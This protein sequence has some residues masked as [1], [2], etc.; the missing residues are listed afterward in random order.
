[1]GQRSSPNDDEKE[2]DGFTFEMIKGDLFTSPQSASLCHCVAR[3][4]GMG[5]GIAV[6]FKRN[7]GGLGELRKQ[8]VPVGGVGVLL[9]DNR[10][11]Y[12]LVTK[13]KSTDLPTSGPLTASLKSMRDHAVAN[14]VKHIAMPKI[15][16]GL[17]RLKW[18]K[19][20]SSIMKIFEE[21]DIR[22]TVY[23]K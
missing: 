19:V 7:F 18:N 5:K 13:K 9:R 14:G 23:E 12:Y 2:T 1:M 6:M 15:G 11:I 17:D 21:T 20:E 3:D 16:S 4:L 22:I 10:F 8:Q